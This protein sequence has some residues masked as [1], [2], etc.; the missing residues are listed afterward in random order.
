LP[1]TNALHLLLWLVND[2][3]TNSDYMSTGTM[4]GWKRLL[5]GRDTG[6]TEQSHAKPVKLAAVVTKTLNNCLININNI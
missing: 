1:E 3:L 5:R 6:G 2:A 4:K